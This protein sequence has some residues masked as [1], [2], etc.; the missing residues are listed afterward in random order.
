[1]Y[2]YFVVIYVGGVR[3]TGNMQSIY[4]FVT[5][6][7]T[8]WAGETICYRSY[9]GGNGVYLLGSTTYV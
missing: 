3:T 8:V 6:C 7:E 4:I 9:D 1:M 5:V 2:K